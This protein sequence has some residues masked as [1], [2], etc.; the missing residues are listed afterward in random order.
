MQNH[1]SRW[2]NLFGII[3]VDID[4]FGCIDIVSVNEPVFLDKDTLSSILW[5]HIIN[6]EKAIG[7]CHQ[8]AWELL[9]PAQIHT[10][11]DTSLVPHVN[12][13]YVLRGQGTDVLQTKHVEPHCS[14]GPVLMHHVRHLGG[15]V[16]AG[17]CEHFAHICRPCGRLL[18]LTDGTRLLQAWKW[19]KL[20][21]IAQITEFWLY[22]CQC[23]V[24]A[25]I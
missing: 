18:L 5:V 23:I 4:I 12:L 16:G 8:Q 6:V 9:N 25:F 19:G 2:V 22:I 20:T 7:G 24:S 17:C 3:T 15:Q 11:H 10:G 13:F 21:L 14:K 1:T